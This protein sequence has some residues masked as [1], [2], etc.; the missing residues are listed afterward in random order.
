M[1]NP[2]N[3]ASRNFAVDYIGG[4]LAATAFLPALSE[5]P[6]E[7]AALRD[8]SWTPLASNEAD[9]LLQFNASAGNHGASHLVE[10]LSRKGA[11]AVVTGQQPNLLASPLYVLY[12]ALTACAKARE[13]GAR[14]ARPIVPIFWVASDDHDFQELRDCWIPAADYSLQNLGSLVSRGTGVPPG[15]PAFEW[16][17]DDAAP[18]LIEKITPL[19]DGRPDWLTASCRGTFEESFCRHIARCLREI[20]ILLLAPRLSFMRR[21]QV[22]ILE[23]ELMDP[24]PAFDALQSRADELAARGYSPLVHRESDVVNSFYVTGRIRGRLRRLPAFVRCENPATGETLCH[25]TSDELLAELHSHPERFSPNVV[26]RPIVQDAALP[27]IAYVGGPSEIAYLA[28]LGPIYELHGVPQSMAILRKSALLVDRRTQEELAGFGIDPNRAFDGTSAVQTPADLASRAVSFLESHLHNTL[29][30][31]DGELAVL[32]AD[33]SSLESNMR[34][35]V[36]DL[37]SRAAS[38]HPHV[39]RGIEK[40]ERTLRLAVDRFRTRLAR[41]LARRDTPAWRAYTRARNMLAPFG[42]PQERILSPIAF[43]E[44]RDP[45]SLTSELLAKLDFRDPRAQVIRLD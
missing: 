44:H 3:R 4:E 31:G 10:A 30:P 18:R 36:E 35:H 37:R 25:F 28:Q 32:A 8:A 13:L 2:A 17:L 1:T 22:P 19:L 9:E 34:R 11:L 26:S 24:G 42:L 43:L 15:S 29:I 7:L 21:R 38:Q 6:S 23:R 33:I 12:K 16:L 41:Q 45:A 39:Q 20:P 14:L 5:T 27:V 40:T